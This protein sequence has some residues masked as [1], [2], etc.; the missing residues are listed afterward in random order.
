M[1]ALGAVSALLVGQNGKAPVTNSTGGTSKGNP[2]AGSQS[3][4]S[5]GAHNKPVTTADRAG[6]GIVTFLLS[7]SA[8]GTFVWMGIGK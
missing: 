8:L 1:N 2:D 4:T 5:I 3:D 6:A 7:A